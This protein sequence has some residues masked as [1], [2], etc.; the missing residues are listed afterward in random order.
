MMRQQR[1]GHAFEAVDE[2]D[3]PAAWI[4]VLD[5]LHEEPFYMAYKARVAELL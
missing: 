2:Q 4:A 3:D 5:R 1:E